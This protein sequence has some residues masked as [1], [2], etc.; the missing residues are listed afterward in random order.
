MAQAWHSHID[1]EAWEA[2]CDGCGKCCM[3]KLED[4]DTGEILHTHV[5]CKLFEADTCRCTQYAQRFT[6]VADCLDIRRMTAA[7]M[8]WLPET[9]AYRLTFEGKPLPDWHHLNTGDERTVHQAGMSMRGKA[10]CER[11]VAEQD[12]MDYIMESV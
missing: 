5:A 1:D 7:Q 11:D 3:H 8:H 4:E 10:V 6:L 9:C 12:L 2:L